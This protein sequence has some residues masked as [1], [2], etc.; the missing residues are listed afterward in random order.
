M[1]LPVAVPDDGDPHRRRRG[2]SR[3]GANSVAGVAMISS[4][5]PRLWSML[6]ERAGGGSVTVGHACAA[7]TMVTEVDGASAVLAANAAVRE[8]VYAG[9]EIAAR[10]EELTLTLGEGPGLDALRQG[11][12]VLTADMAGPDALV[13]WPVFAPAAVAAGA[14]AVFALPLRMGAMRLGVLTLYRGRPGSL[15]RGQVADGLALADVVFLLLFDRID[16]T[17]GAAPSDGGFGADG[18]RYPEVHQATGMI[19]V[20]LGVTAEIAFARLR[21]HAFARNRRLRDVA[22][23]VVTRRLRFNPD[24]DDYADHR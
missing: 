9:D 24:D 19:I 13:R 17:S 5:D 14:L 2:V 8:T 16:P 1:C 12:P 10:V 22:R 6:V 7:I 3:E 15:S 4:P 21:A 20:Q 11:E 23:D 18:M